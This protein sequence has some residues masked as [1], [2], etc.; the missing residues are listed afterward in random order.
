MFEVRAWNLMSTVTLATSE[1]EV[2]PKAWY[3]LLPLVANVTPA[4]SAIREPEVL[5]KTLHQVLQLA[6]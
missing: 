2:L 1:P 5:R 3:V 6:A 4:T